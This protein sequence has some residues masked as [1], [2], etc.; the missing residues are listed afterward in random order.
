MQSPRQQN[1]FSQD[2]CVCFF[3]SQEKFIQIQRNLSE[4]LT[5][6]NFVINK[7][8]HRFIFSV[9]FK[10]DYFFRWIIEGERI[11]IWKFFNVSPYNNLSFTKQS[12]QFTETK[13]IENFRM[14][15]SLFLPIICTA[16]SLE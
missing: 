2:N 12:V 16:A 1:G 9:K 8:S 3:S 5:M 14:L 7:H 15:T 10:Y 11:F 4:T 6:Y 13:I